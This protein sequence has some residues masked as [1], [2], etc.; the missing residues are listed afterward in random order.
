MINILEENTATSHIFNIHAAAVLLEEGWV[1]NVR[2]VISA[3]CVRDIVRGVKPL[4]CDACFDFIIP[5]LDN[6][7]S[8]AFQRAMSGLAERRGSGQDSFWSWR[9]LMY[10]QALALDPDALEVIA[11]WAFMEML[12]AGFTRVGEFHYLHHD[13][14]GQPYDDPAEMAKRIVAA[15]R[16]SGIA[17]TFLPVFYAHAGFGGIS[18]HEDQ[19]RFIHTLENFARLWQECHALMD[20]IPA[21]QLGLAIHSLRA[22]TPEE[23]QQLVLLG[24]NRP[25][26][27]HIAEQV[28]EVEDCLQW[29]GARPV[30]WLFDN[31]PVNDHW[32]LIHATHMNVQEIKALAKSGATAGLCPITEANLGDG[33]FPMPIFLEQGGHFAI[34][35]DSNILISIAQELRQLEYSQRLSQ[36]VRNVI[37]DAGQS[38]GLRLLMETVRGGARSVQGTG[39]IAIGKRADFVSLTSE[40]WVDL[41]LETLL[42]QWIFGRGIAVDCVFVGGKKRV[43]AGRHLD[44]D[45]ISA[46]FSRVMRKLRA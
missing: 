41:S 39:H 31:A 25:I 13:R 33:I 2:L 18:P 21:G 30:E 11:S 24:E 23:L 16:T 42:D 20:E 38:T 40:D 6:V 12:E 45:T 29:S 36:R 34:G 37:A 28:K 15:A 14:H 43:D 7:H 17:L 5:G 3:G 44:R 19:R 8:H 46:H 22:T 9:N 26:H 10:N 27:I 4:P 1:E 35:S 32:T